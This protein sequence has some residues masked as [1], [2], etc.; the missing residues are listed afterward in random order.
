MADE[1][2]EKQTSEEK[3]KE[4]EEKAKGEITE[5]K[6]EEKVKEEIREIGAVLKEAQGIKAE[7]AREEAE[8]RGEKE[9]I[10]RQKVIKKLKKLITVRWALALFVLLAIVF[11]VGF[12]FSLIPV[13]LLLVIIGKNVLYARMLSGKRIPPFFQYVTF[14]GDLAVFTLLIN[15]T[16]GAKS[17]FCLGYYLIIMAVSFYFSLPEIVFVVGMSSL[18]YGLYVWPGVGETG[19][20]DA[21]L[22]IGFFFITA[23]F[24]ASGK[25]VCRQLQAGEKI[26]KLI[27]NTMRRVLPFVREKEGL[28]E[29][30]GL[31]TGE[32][33]EKSREL[34]TVRKE[35]EVVRE[36]EKTL[37]PSPGG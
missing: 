3:G 31:L 37:T 15:F 22:K 7:I 16:G 13:G 35:L 27:I 20:L 34:E 10:A 11:R 36:K 30:V 4:V 23:V 1:D 28:K 25:T 14:T 6:V 29:K 21:G 8:E 24:V 5:V 19:L 33:A 32:L 12:K 18:V 9:L 17:I 26:K 2:K